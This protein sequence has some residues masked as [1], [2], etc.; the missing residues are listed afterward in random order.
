LGFVIIV[1]L[2]IFTNHQIHG[3]ARYFDFNLLYTPV[4]LISA[5]VGSLALINIAKRI[6]SCAVLEYLGKES[7]ILYIFQ[8]AIIKRL[9]YAISLVWFPNSIFEIIAYLLI[10]LIITVALCSAIAA[11]IE[12]KYLKWSIGR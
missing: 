11:L 6:D 1:L 4:F 7:L 12:T 5:V 9:E 10:V 3:V 8:F 2:H